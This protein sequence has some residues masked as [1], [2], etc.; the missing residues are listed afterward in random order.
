[1]VFLYSWYLVFCKLVKR[2][3]RLSN[4]LAK[5]VRQKPIYP[6][7]SINS[8]DNPDDKPIRS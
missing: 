3:R 2:R 1:M 7:L 5:L 6:Q 4:S 8:T